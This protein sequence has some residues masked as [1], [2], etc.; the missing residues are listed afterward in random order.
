MSNKGA[1]FD[2][3][4]KPFSHNDLWNIRTPDVKI[5]HKNIATIL[6]ESR[7]LYH[8]SR[9]TCRGIL[10]LTKEQMMRAF[11]DN[12][13]APQIRNYRALLGSSSMIFTPGPGQLAA[14][15][16]KGSTI[17]CLPGRSSFDTCHARGRTR[18]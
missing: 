2:E 12:R 18:W 4:L 7:Q 9:K 14:P 11:S 10:H 6:P 1:Y 15:S 17:P 3:F 5:S 16:V 13:I 8:L